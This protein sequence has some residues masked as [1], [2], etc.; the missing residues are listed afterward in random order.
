MSS[1]EYDLEPETENEPDYFTPANIVRSDTID[2]IEADVD[3]AITLVENNNLIVN[4][5]LDSESENDELIDYE[6]EYN[7]NYNYNYNYEDEVEDDHTYILVP[8]V[9]NQVY[10]EDHWTIRISTGKTVTL[11]YS[12]YYRWCEVAATVTLQEREYILYSEH[13]S[14]DD[15]NMVVVSLYDPWKY[16]SM[17][18]NHDTYSSDEINEINHL[19]YI[20]GYC[21][22]DY[23][24]ETGLISNQECDESDLIPE[25]L[26][27]NGWVLAD[28]EHH[29]IDGGCSLDGRIG[30]CNT[31]VIEDDNESYNENIV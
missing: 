17:I 14:I 28:T 6:Y 16:E 11:Q 24:V 1:F 22:C 23:S 4:V 15:H 26:E 20:P 2:I 30:W 5:N 10:K 31:P 29:I 25:V 3:R 8:R 12:T 21:V 19:R 7:Y 9:E 18:R 27:I 13:I